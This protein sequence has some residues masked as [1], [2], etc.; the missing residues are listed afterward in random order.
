M[1]PIRGREG[2]RG[3]AEK[4]G[5]LKNPWKSMMAL[6]YPLDRVGALLGAARVF[7]GCI[8]RC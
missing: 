2:H 1:V 5:S 3:D 6:R 7:W 8:G 4:L